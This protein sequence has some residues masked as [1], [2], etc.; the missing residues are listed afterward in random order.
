LKVPRSTA[1]IHHGCGISGRRQMLTHLNLLQI[2]AW[3]AGS[4][5]IQKRTTTRL[6]G[7]S[8][9]QETAT[10]V[11]HPIDGCIKTGFS[12]DE[13]RLIHAEVAFRT[14]SELHQQGV[15]K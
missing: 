9:A 14:I 3:W 1:K 2:D 10:R 15:S 12:R 13:P 8:A 7:T 11:D 5:W 4:T 6:T